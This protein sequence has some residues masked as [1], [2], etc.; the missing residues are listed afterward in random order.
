MTIRNIIHSVLIV[1]L[2]AAGFNSAANAQNVSKE[3][4]AQITVLQSD[5]PASEKAIAC[6]HLAVHGSDAAVP[7][8]AK[9]LP[10][11]KLS[12]WA[13]IALE[14]IP[15]AVVDEALRKASE[16]LEGR[17]LVGVINSIGNRRDAGAVELLVK[18]LNGKDVTAGSVAAVALGKIAN[19]PAREALKSALAV[20]NDDLRNAVAEGY[21]LCAEKLHR[22]GKATAAVAVYEEI[23]QAKL[24]K[25][26]IVEATRG[27]ILARGQ[28]GLPLL[29]ET[30]RSDD[31]KMFQL[32]LGTVREFPGSDVDAALAKELNS[33]APARAELIVQAMADRSDTVLLAAVLKSAEQGDAVVRLSAINALQ[34]VGDV[35]CLAPLVKIA[36]GNDESLAVAANETLTVLR[37]ESVNKQV[38]A[39]VADADGATY[40]LLI[41]LIGQRLIKAVPVLKKALASNDS[42]TR[43]AALMSLGAT[44]PLDQLGL[45]I[46]QVLSPDHAADLPAATNALRTASVRMP[47]RDAC[48][49][50]LAKAVSKA[51]TETK[52]TLLEIISE[53]GGAKSLGTLATAAKSDS[54]AL[55]D[56][57]SRLLGKWNGVDAAPVLLDL[58]STA[59]AGKYR[60]RALRG[61]LGL[62]R[63]FSMPPRQRADMCNK[64]MKVATRTTEQKLALD[65][66]KI[67]PSVPGLRLAAAARKNPKLSDHAKAT[68]NAIAAALRK[69][70]VNVDSVLSGS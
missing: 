45:L 11:P 23:R 56:T 35:S 60:I 9:L 69:R 17:Q 5:A 15:G 22:D 3:E 4:Q 34:R 8:L 54:D 12:S 33:A 62:A 42:E 37:G 39:M 16:T 70:G 32:A 43:A 29:L 14:A 28:E 48:A 21:V 64:A 58:A 19:Q 25:Q 55:Q 10:D 51:K 31:K 27:A 18:R 68:T 36:T 49:T 26:R 30:L 66:L 63:K 1:S 61:Y 65:V 46:D 24:P 47:D 2:A 50:E 7:E 40:R 20:A 52:S 13:R 38:L 59:P 6:K 44:V 57:A 41:E 53:V 67:H